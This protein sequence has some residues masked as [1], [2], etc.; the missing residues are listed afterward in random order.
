MI[1]SVFIPG[2][3]DIKEPFEIRREVF[4]TEQGYTEKED[5]DAFDDQ[6]LHLVVYVDEAPAATGRIWYDGQ[7]FWVGRLAVRKEYRGQKLGDLALRLLVY[8]AFSMGAQ[9]LFVG[10]QTYIMPLYRKF[11]FREYGA[12]YMEGG[13]PHMAMKVTKDTVAYPS[14][15]HGDE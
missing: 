8:K 5:F 10:A 6:A 9:E 4:I 7:D 13:I 15:C 3:Q 12:E 2:N 1:T 11:G 14:A